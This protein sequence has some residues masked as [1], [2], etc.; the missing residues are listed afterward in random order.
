MQLMIYHPAMAAKYIQ[1]GGWIHSRS[2][3]SHQGVSQE[4]NDSGDN[5]DDSQSKLTT[6]KCA[7]LTPGHRSIDAIEHQQDTV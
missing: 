5:N 1:F 2:L 4:D 3:S 6:V 7:D